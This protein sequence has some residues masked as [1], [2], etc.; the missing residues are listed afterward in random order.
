MFRSSD[1][2]NDS[3][4]SEKTGKVEFVVAAAP[5]MPAR[6]TR[7]HR[8]DRPGRDKSLPEFR[9]K[10]DTVHP[11]SKIDPSNLFSCFQFDHLDAIPM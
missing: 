2:N 9:C 10:S 8:I 11:W 1:G 7:F 5:G 3:P 6:A 4:W